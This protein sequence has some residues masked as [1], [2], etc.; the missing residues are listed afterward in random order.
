[1]AADITGANKYKKSKM[2]YDGATYAKYNGADFFFEHI[3]VNPDKED[4][5]KTAPGSALMFMIRTHIKPTD[6]V[7]RDFLNELCRRLCQ[8]EAEN[9]HY[10]GDYKQQ[11]ILN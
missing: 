7:N 8:D 4:I 3:V 11:N 2:A 10:F 6:N 9:K 5:I 1:M